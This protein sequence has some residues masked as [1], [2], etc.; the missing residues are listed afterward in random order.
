[1][2]RYQQRCVIKF[3]FLQGKRYKAIHH[4]LAAV[5]AEEAVSG[6][7]VKRWCRRFKNGDFAIEDHER[8][9]RP[10]SDLA[11]AITRFLQDEPFL[12]ARLLAKRLATSHH[13]IKGI[14]EGALGLRKFARRWVP[15]ELTVVQKENRVVE[16][17][18]LLSML[19]ADVGANFS[20]IMTGDESWFFY[21]YESDAM[22]VADR[23][24]V[25]PRT[26]HMIGSKKVMIT[27]FF[28]G[29]RLI[30][31]QYLPRGRKYNKEYFT[32]IILEDI[33]QTCNHG[34]GQRRTKDM[35]IHMDNCRVHNCQESSCKIQRM[36]M[37]RLPHPAYSPDL[38][39]CDFW[40]FGFAK[41]S[42]RDLQFDSP[43]AIIEHLSD[44]FDG[45]TFDELQSVFHE[46]I[47]RLRWVIDHEGDYFIK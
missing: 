13:T 44:L 29:V 1:M 42:F 39:P 18:N 20:H 24:D 17:T 11:E 41:T 12:S 26:S 27:I 30:A 19:E 28:T 6:E 31:L 46:W 34:H 15:H 47:Q 22:Y 36:K 2:D 32:N 40:F 43:E 7:T 4:E 8:S 14:L 9:G 38:S 16:A 5:L 37:T 35:F 21:R 33:D 10:R 25:I 3:L 23:A 45:L